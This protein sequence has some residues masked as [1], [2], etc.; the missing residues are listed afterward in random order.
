MAR[1][2]LYSLFQEQSSVIYSAWGKKLIF[3][4]KRHLEDIVK[5]SSP[6]H[7]LVRICNM[8]Q[9]QIQQSSASLPCCLWGEN[10]CTTTLPIAYNM[11]MGWSTHEMWEMRVHASMEKVW[12]NFFPEWMLLPLGSHR[13]AF[14]SGKHAFE[15]FSTTCMKPGT[16]LPCRDLFA[17]YYSSLPTCSPASQVR[18]FFTPQRLP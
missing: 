14:K 1:L 4:L 12:N 9:S 5:D 2:F 13:L 7:Y 6:G 16:P 18:G 11:G 3:I 10:E 17:W 8:A 15:R